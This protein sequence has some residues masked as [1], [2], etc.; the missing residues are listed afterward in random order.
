MFQL[1]E[2]VEQRADRQAGEVEGVAVEFKGWADGLC[3]PKCSQTHTETNE[4]LNASSSSCALSGLE[5]SSSSSSLSLRSLSLS[6]DADYMSVSVILQRRLI[7][8]RSPQR[9]SLKCIKCCI[10]LLSYL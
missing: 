5:P 6:S 3:A 10:A 2:T 8:G 7:S 9:H 1:E 4:P